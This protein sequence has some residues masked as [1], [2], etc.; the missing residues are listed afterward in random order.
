[1]FRQASEHKKPDHQPSANYSRKK[2]QMGGAARCLEPLS[3]SQQSFQASLF[4]AENHR[5]PG[6]TSTR[7]LRFAMNKFNAMAF[8]L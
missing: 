7:Q 6:K 5:S 2:D 3:P 1:M 8:Y 4:S